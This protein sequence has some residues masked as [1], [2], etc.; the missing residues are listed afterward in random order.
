[1][2]D[3]M[4]KQELSDLLHELECAVNEGITSKENENVYPRI[5]YWPYVEKDIVASGSGYA[6]LVTYQISIFDRVPQ[7]SLY[8]KL[9][10]ILRMK[11]ILPEFYHEYIENDP[12]FQKAWH[13]YFSIDVL[14]KIEDSENE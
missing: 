8:K 7:S 10:Q 1:M 11:R 3:F 14:E 4:T 13:T 9:R 5:V 12:M 2:S 6:N